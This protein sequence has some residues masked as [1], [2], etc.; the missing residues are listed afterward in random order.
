[1]NRLIITYENNTVGAYSLLVEHKECYG[2]NIMI[3][4]ER[5]IYVL[6]Q[7]I[8]SVPDTIQYVFVFH[9]T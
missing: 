6:Q 7:V 1:M 4:E 2:V 3:S 5:Y 9:T 8:Y